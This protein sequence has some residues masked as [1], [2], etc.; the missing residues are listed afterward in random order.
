MKTAPET[1][2]NWGVVLLNMGGPRS[3]DDIEPFLT[4]LL[5][6]PAVTGIPIGFV[7]RAL[8]R[9]IARKRAPKV[10]PHYREIGG[11]SPQ[12]PQTEDQARALEAAL[13]DKGWPVTLAMSYSA[14]R[15]AQAI[16]ELQAKGVTHV[17]ALPLYP[18]ACGAT[19]RAALQSFT[20]EAEAAGLQVK[21]ID[22]F[23]DL[24]GFAEAMARQIDAR[25]PYLDHPTLLFSAH[26][27]PQRMVNKGDPYPKQVDATVAAIRQRLP[28]GIDW[29]LAFQSRLGPVTWMKPYLDETVAALGAKGV[30]DIVLVPVSFVSEHIETLYELDIELRTLAE[31]AGIRRFERIPTVQTDPLF[32][33]GLAERLRRSLREIQQEGVE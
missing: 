14:P 22:G 3:L 5:S 28:E 2:T 4:E 27:L 20:Q 24:D 11:G 30:K 31:K 23:A 33:D 17:F 6:D 12:V 16:G 18:Q 21:P 10:A 29:T 19:S 9:R 1:E 7:R 26:G 8:A 15:A 25:L 13:A 32:I